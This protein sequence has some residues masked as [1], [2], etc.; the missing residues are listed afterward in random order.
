MVSVRSG[1]ARDES[2]ADRIYEASVLPEL[3]PAVLRDL[4]AAAEAREAVL[5]AASAPEI[6]YVASSERVAELLSSHYSYTAGQE[7]TRRLLALRQPGFFS[8]FDVFSREELDSEP[9]FTEFLIPRGY[10]RGIATAIEV[11]EG[12]T[13][14]VHA[15]GDFRDGQFS[16]ALVGRLNRLRPHL[17]RSALIS[18]RLSFERARTAVETLAGLGLAACAVN[19][20]G[21]VLVAN[22]DFVA[23]ASHWTTRGGGRVAL[24]DR[25]ADAMLADT[26]SAIDREAGVRSLPLRAAAGRQP[27]VLHVVPIRR[28]AHELF[29]H[30]A[31]ILVLTRASATPT[32]ATPLLQALFDLSPAEA[33]IAARVA[34]GQTIEAIA[35]ASA[36][37]SHTVRNQLKNVLEKT[38]CPRQA[39][40]ARLLAQLVPGER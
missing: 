26:L 7:R 39:D 38:G 10:G 18:A 37:S 9:L 21:V 15:E 34:A 3:W 1:A 24:E 19:R 30:A 33:D 16:E 5:L 17:A 25:R 40:L 28:A 35:L 12:D 23:A 22:E 13:I 11:P 6:R 2:L 20:T 14:V 36:R 32:G 4:A 29:T 8:D 31:A 27:A